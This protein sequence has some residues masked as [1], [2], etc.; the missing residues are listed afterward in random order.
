MADIWR[1]MLLQGGESIARYVPSETI[2]MRNRNHYYAA[3]RQCKALQST[4]P[5]MEFMAACFAT[6]AKEVAEEAQ[7]LFEKSKKISPEARAKQILKFA[8]TQDHFQMKDII[9]LLADTPRRTLERDI[10]NL[11]KK[12]KIKPTSCKRCGS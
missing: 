12:K 3:I 2:V 5:M 9:E 8:K 7:T 11:V 4:H 6:A 10:E 1:I